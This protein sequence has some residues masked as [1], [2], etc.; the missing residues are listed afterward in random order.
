[1]L[2]QCLAKIRERPESFGLNFA[3]LLT[4]TVLQFVLMN[5]REM[6]DVS[7]SGDD[8]PREQLDQAVALLE[9]QEDI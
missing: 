8:I 5:R 3:M 9:M 2:F 7:S 1:V 4:A 6:I